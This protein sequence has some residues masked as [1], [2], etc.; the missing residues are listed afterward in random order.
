[1]VDDDVRF[2]EQVGAVLEGAYDVDLCHAIAEFR[3]RF[4][5]KR[6]HLVIMDMRLEKG[7]EGLELL[8]ETLR[9]DP[10]QPVIIVTAYADTE[11]YVAALEAGAL[12]YLDKHE[13][14]PTLIARMVQGLLREGRLQRCVRVLEEEV[15]FRSTEL[16]GASP[17]TAH[18]RRRLRVAADAEGVP[19]L[20]QGE[21]GVGK[22]QA[23]RQLHELGHDRELMHF[24]TARFQSVSEEH[25]VAALAGS[26]SEPGNI[27]RGWLEEA[28]DGTLYVPEVS[29]MNPAAQEL[30][31]STLSVGHFR[32]HGGDEH[33]AFSARFVAGTV[34]SLR[35]AVQRGDFHRGL[36]GVL[37]RFEISVPPLRERREDIALLATHF[38]Q[39]LYRL[40]STA[41]RSFSV[42]ATA[43]LE[44]HDWPGNVKELRLAVEQAALSAQMR[45]G[46]H[47]IP[48]DLPCSV[49]APRVSGPKPQSHLNYRYNLARAEVELVDWA[50]RHCDDTRRAALANELG[51]NDR[52]TLVRRV[53]RA[54]QGFPELRHEFPEAAE[55]FPLKGR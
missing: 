27:R 5:V 14:T 17:G 43:R 51:Y 50:C 30:L 7:Y 29:T 42:D 13:F 53:M 36:Y 31:A 23:A 54:F 41:A 19:I 52:F 45:S 33:I 47:I 44:G 40:G 8:R 35:G 16:V 2:A 26:E 38:L 21:L 12:T 4:C 9:R 49:V 32:R 46:M 18:L 6:Y 11:T 55:V 48:E 34:L 39:H 28:E 24:V 20:I 15:A 37:N 22:E 1:V 10:V 25:H 3:A